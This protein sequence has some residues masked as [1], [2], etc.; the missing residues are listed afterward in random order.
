MVQ[1][2]MAKDDSPHQELIGR[3]YIATQTKTVGQNFLQIA[4]ERWNKLFFYCPLWVL[5]GM[6]M[7]LFKKDI[8]ETETGCS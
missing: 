5:H 7:L 6:E 2:G 8:L 1:S 4:A 3:L